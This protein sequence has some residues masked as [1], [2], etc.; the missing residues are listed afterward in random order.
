[1]KRLTAFSFPLVVAGALGTIS[2]QLDKLVV[3]SMCSPEVFAVYS[4]AA[5]EIPLV[6]IVTGS[7]AAVIQPDLRRMV[8]AGSLSDALGLFRRA[9]E[10]SAVLLVPLTAFLLASAESFIVTLFSEKY[11]AS[12]MPFRLYLLIL[13]GRMVNF[14][15]FMIALGQNK[16]ILY[17]S[18]V[19]LPTNLLLSVL[20]VRTFGFLGAIVSTITVV[21]MVGWTWNFSV[22]RR[23]VGCRWQDVIPIAAIAKLAWVSAG[24]AVPVSLAVALRLPIPPAAQL[25]LN[26]ALFGASLL[27]LAWALSVASIMTEVRALADRIGRRLGGA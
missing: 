16:A 14:G 10:R 18:L 6:G 11:L 8:V 12:V 15:A 24:A 23:T 13:P 27:T 4:I 5:V 19:G 17:R 22:I 2:L 9:A 25:F 1:M 7:I 3:A 20:L 21:Y 26:G